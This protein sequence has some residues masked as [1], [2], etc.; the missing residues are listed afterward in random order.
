MSIV[1]G[2]EKRENFR[3]KDLTKLEGR[4]LSV[5][6]RSETTPRQ[7]SQGHSDVADS[8]IAWQYQGGLNAIRAERDGQIHLDP[9]FSFER[10]RTGFEI[11]L[12][13]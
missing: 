8:R 12:H 2:K 3:N 4:S 9:M 6:R 11:D 1:I 10:K 13:R 5:L 7:V